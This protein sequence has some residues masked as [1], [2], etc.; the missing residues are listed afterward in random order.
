MR[1][2]TEDMPKHLFKFY[3]FNEYSL[4]HLN[5]GSFYFSHPDDYNDPFDSSFSKSH[6]SGLGADEGLNEIENHILK[7]YPA[8]KTRETSGKFTEKFLND[9]ASF[10]DETLK[11][12]NNGVRNLG[13]CC[14]SASKNSY[15]A[16]TLMWSHYADKHQGFC[17]KFRTGEYPFDA[18]TL[19]KVGYIKSGEGAKFPIVTPLNSTPVL[20][21]EIQ[22][23]ALNIICEKHI[24][25]E[26]EQEWRL[27]VTNPRQRLK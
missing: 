8:Y 16:S 15:P 11:N 20:E 2:K 9:T 13:I 17:L 27:V 7:E 5:E 26:Y 19:N 1:V 6:L 14:F 3:S 22:N 12:L 21:A 10:L 24:D 18:K 25:W 4:I 23:C